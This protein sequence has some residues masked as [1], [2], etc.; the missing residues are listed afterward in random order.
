MFPPAFKN[1]A[2]TC[3]QE[4]PLGAAQNFALVPKTLG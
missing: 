1:V 3:S 2:G 4:T